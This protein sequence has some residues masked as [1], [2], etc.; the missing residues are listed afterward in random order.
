MK[1]SNAYVSFEVKMTAV[2]EKSKT[3]YITEF[4]PA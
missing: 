2:V 4:T 3:F 1:H